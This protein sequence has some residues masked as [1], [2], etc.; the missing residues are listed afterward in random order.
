MLI[1][2]IED[3]ADQWLIRSALTQ[4]FPETE[5]TGFSN[6]VQC[7]AHP[8]NCSSEKNRI[9]RLILIEVHLPR[10]DE[11]M[12][13]LA[14]VKSHPFYRQVPAIVL[15]TSETHK[16]SIEWFTY[17]STF[18][19]GRPGMH[20]QWQ[21]GFYTFRRYCLDWGALSFRLP[22]VDKTHVS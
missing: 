15:T 16:E 21:T 4:R 17:G 20:H 11:G 7:L 18:Y 6:A 14:S 8:E 10:R 12:A 9:S 2:M 5:L 13:L 22:K 1:L 3:N 19:F